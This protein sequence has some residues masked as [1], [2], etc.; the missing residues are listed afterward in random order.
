MQII[1]VLFFV[2]GAT[3]GIPAKNQS[4]VR[5]SLLEE[6]L[7]DDYVADFPFYVDGLVRGDPGG[8][9]L[10]PTYAQ[11]ADTFQ[12]IP[13]RSDDVWVITFPKCGN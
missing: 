6:S 7:S 5:F 1:F 13:L 3:Y 10:T 11:V 4:A 8:F 2:T 12:K 9:V